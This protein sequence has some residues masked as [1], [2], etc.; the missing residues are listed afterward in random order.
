MYFYVKSGPG[1]FSKFEGEVSLMVSHKDDELATKFYSVEEALEIA[2]K[3]QSEGF[4]ATI[5]PIFKE[6]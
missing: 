6:D 3:L 2:K 1:Y 5:E 4:E